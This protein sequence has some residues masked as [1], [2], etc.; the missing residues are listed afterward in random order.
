MEKTW[1]ELTFE[2]K[3]YEVHNSVLFSHKMDK[4]KMNFL[5]MIVQRLIDKTNGMSDDEINKFLGY[6][7]FS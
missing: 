4:N 2:E 6:E 5:A 3:L 7:S 1:F